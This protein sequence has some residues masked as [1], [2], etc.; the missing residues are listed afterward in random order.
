MIHDW[1][2]NLHTHCLCVQKLYVN[3]IADLQK[4]AR[5]VERCCNLHVNGYS[6]L[7]P[8]L[9]LVFTLT[10][11]SNH[12]NYNTCDCEEENLQNYL[13]LILQCQYYALVHISWNIQPMHISR[14]SYLPAILFSYQSVANIFFHFAHL[15][16]NYNSLGHKWNKKAPFLRAYSH[17]H[18]PSTIFGSLHQKP[19][20]SI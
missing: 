14:F 18:K 2:K 10:Y 15:T 9:Y 4:V 1:L 13:F 17:A 6:I 19:H 3:I 12:C 7:L 20:F 11:K 8:K 16:S 5:K